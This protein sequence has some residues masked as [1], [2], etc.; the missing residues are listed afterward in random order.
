MEAMEIR[1]LVKD[2][3][4]IMYDTVIEDTAVV[5]RMYYTTLEVPCKATLIQGTVL[6]AQ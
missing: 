5:K 1:R 4:G 6:F 2:M 3:E